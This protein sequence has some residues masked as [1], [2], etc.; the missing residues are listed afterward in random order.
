MPEAPNT[1]A[2]EVQVV[3]GSVIVHNVVAPAFTDTVPVGVPENCGVT[4]EVYVI[5]CS[6]PYTT[7]AADNVNDVDDVA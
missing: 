5:V 7:E 3:A 6:F 2:D 1:V 4:A